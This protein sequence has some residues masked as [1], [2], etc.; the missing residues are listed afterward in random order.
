MNLK[1]YLFLFIVFLSGCSAK[2]N[3]ELIVNESDEIEVAISTQTNLA[4][5]REV[6]ERRFVDAP[7]GLRVRN[8]PSIGAEIIGVLPDVT[9]VISIKEERSINEIDGRRGRW[10]FIETVDMQGWVFGGFLSW[11][12]LRLH[13]FERTATLTAKNNFDDILNFIKRYLNWWSHR[14]SFEYLMSVFSEDGNYSISSRRTFEAP[15][16]WGGVVIEET[17]IVSGPY[18]LKLWDD[19]MII[20]LTIRLSYDNFLALFPYR[21]MQEFLADA[22]FGVMFEQTGN[23]IQYTHDE[24]GAWTLHFVNNLLH[25]ITHTAFIS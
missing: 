20:D 21:T 12:P 18:T 4:N 5:I 16:L 23:S 25:S 10:T 19:T 11:R 3:G 22:N 2:N 14:N 15:S 13:P 9:E 8:S 7:A 24:D 1:V 6:N 17:W